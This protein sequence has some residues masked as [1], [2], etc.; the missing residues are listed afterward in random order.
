MAQH[1]VQRQ[2]FPFCCP[3]S[4]QRTVPRSLSSWSQK[5]ERTYRVHLQYAC[6]PHTPLH[7]G[8]HSRYWGC[9]S[10]GRSIRVYQPQ[11]PPFSK[12]PYSRC[13]P[14][15]NLFSSFRYLSTIHLTSFPP[16]FTPATNLTK[17]R[18]MII[19]HLDRMHKRIRD[20]QSRIL[21][22]KPLTDLFLERH[23]MFRQR[24]DLIEKFRRDDDDF[25]VR[26][27]DGEGT[28][29][30]LNRSIHIVR[31]HD[32]SQSPFPDHLPPKTKTSYAFQ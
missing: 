2:R 14:N 7:L 19:T 15:T 18:K 28:V 17:K 31:T 12:P 29:F 26:G 23:L 20:P 10:S 32:Q 1:M 30:E 13:F 25:F 9:S 8:D 24:L 3:H 6:P 21:L 5:L 27:W 22:Q 16:L 11:P 4:H